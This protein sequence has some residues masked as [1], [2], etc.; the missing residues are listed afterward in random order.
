MLDSILP[1]VKVSDFVG[2]LK[3]KSSWFNPIIYKLYQINVKSNVKRK[4]TTMDA[5]IRSKQH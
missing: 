1:K 4:V 2:Y 5:V 3:E